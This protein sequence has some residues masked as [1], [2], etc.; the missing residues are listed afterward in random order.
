[1]QRMDSW[2]LWKAVYSVSTVSILCCT[3]SVGADL[4]DAVLTKGCG[5]LRL[6]ATL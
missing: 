3:P 4:S 6:V 2:P 5:A 1:M